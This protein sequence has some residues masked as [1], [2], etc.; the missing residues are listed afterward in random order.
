[1]AIWT[2]RVD[3]DDDTEDLYIVHEA[4][5]QTGQ[6]HGVTVYLGA[7]EI[8]AQT[9]RLIDWLNHIAPDG[10]LPQLPDEDDTR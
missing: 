5:E 2:L 4:L 3:H 8:G 6:D 1:M 9:M 10:V 7:E